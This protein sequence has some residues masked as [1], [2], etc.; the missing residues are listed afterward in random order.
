MLLTLFLTWQVFR[1]KQKRQEAE[2]ELRYFK[3]LFEDSEGAYIV[4][5]DAKGVI[6]FFNK[7]AQTLLGYR[8]DEVVGKETPVLFHD[9]DEIATLRERLEKE[10]ALPLTP[11]YALTH[12]ARKNQLE[13]REVA[14]RDKEKNLFHLLLSVSSLKNAKGEIIGYLGVGVDESK[15]FETAQHCREKLEAHKQTLRL[16][17]LGTWTWEIQTGQ[18]QA[19][20]QCYRLLGHLPHS[21]TVTFE[22]WMD[23]IHPDDRA[24]VQK[25]LQ[26]QLAQGDETLVHCSYSNANGHWVRMETYGK[27][28]ERGE[29]GEAKRMVGTMRCLNNGHRAQIHPL[30]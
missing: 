10:L 11:F 3:L 23:F 4:A 8:A 17:G 1:Q 22:T 20:D 6:S 24:S 21:F 19:D 13:V 5:T 15:Q 27:V 9:A 2:K 16:L 26:E 28:I 25:A 7:G 12:A 14:L 29:N 18:I 30:F